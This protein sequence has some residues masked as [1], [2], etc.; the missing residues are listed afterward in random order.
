M[1]LPPSYYSGVIRFLFLSLDW[2]LLCTLTHCLCPYKKCPIGAYEDLVLGAYEG[3]VLVVRGLGC[4]CCV[5]VVGWRLDF[6]S[7]WPHIIIVIS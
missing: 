4:E 3:L 2:L 5:F 1:V 7:E 6:R